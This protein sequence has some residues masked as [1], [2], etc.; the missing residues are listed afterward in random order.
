VPKTFLILK[1]AYS[2]SIG[3]TPPTSGGGG[4]GQCIKI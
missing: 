2:T 4:G 1:L 3:P